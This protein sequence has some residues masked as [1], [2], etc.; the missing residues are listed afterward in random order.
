MKFIQFQWTSSRSILLGHKVRGKG[1]CMNQ[2]KICILGHGLDMVETGM[3][4]KELGF[5]PEK[6]CFILNGLSIVHIIIT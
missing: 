5:Y 6:Q 2:K 4:V 3:N 1:Q